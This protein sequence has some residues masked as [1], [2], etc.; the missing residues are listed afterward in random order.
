MTPEHQTKFILFNVR[1]FVPA[2][3]EEQ[4][5]RVEMLRDIMN[6]DLNYISKR[7]LWHIGNVRQIDKTSFSFRLGRH[8]SR[9]YG[10]LVDGDFIE[11]RISDYPSTPG[12]IDIRTGACA[13]ARNF[14]LVKDN[15]YLGSAFQ[16]VLSKSNLL[17]FHHVVNVDAMPDPRSFIQHIEDA[18]AVTRFAVWVK[19]PNTFDVNKDIIKP[20]EQ[21]VSDLEGQKAR[22]SI[23]GKNL[24]KPQLV[25]ASRSVATTGDGAEA[26]IVDKDGRTDT[27][28]L[29]GANASFSVTL[30]D[31]LD[32]DLTRVVQRMRERR[33][34]IRKGHT[35]NE[36]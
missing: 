6:G 32:D 33:D 13:I 34:Q 31:E 15:D 17:P 23:T 27:V 10:E 22:T 26:S 35:G 4:T 19:R 1:I 28:K 21:T 25:D 29:S 5:D 11:E 16:K 36:D 8:K 18:V 24:D 12:V 30:N 9:K 20:L 14:E 7:T 2:L 3:F